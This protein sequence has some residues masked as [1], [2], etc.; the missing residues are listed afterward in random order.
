M[1]VGAGGGGGIPTSY[2]S[3]RKDRGGVVVSQSRQRGL[4]REKAGG[5]D[6]DII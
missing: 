2:L 6:T 1:A 3:E 5:T 4:I